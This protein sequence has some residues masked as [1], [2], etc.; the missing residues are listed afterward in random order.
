MQHWSPTF[1]PSTALISTV[2]VWVR[3]PN[4]SLHMWNDPSLHAI[5]NVMG[6]FHNICLNTT[7]FFRTTYARI[8]VQMDLNEGL[9]VELKIVNQEYSWTQALDYENVSFRCR[10]CYNIK[11]M[12]KAY[13]KTSQSY[14]HHKAM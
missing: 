9:L 10:S 6:Q 4:L 13:P 7:K 14:R 3:L 5:G 11:H 1:N 12:A 2:L 8:C